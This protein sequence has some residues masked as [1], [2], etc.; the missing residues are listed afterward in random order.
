MPSKK[1]GRPR[2]E[3][4]GKRHRTLTE[5]PDTGAFLNGHP[6]INASRLYN[7][8]V[9]AIMKNDPL[10]V[11]YDE[12]KR[13]LS[14][15]EFEYRSKANRM[16][17]IE[18]IIE[19]NR[20]VQTDLRIEE[21]CGAW[22]LRSL[23]VDGIFHVRKV[24]IDTIMKSEMLVKIEPDLLHETD[25]KTGEFFI[26][27]STERLSYHLASRLVKAGYYYDRQER[28][29]AYR[30]PPSTVSPEEQTLFSR[31]GL[32]MKYDNFT[33]A[34]IAGQ[35][36]GSTPLAVLR[37]FSPE[38][39]KDDLKREIIARMLPDYDPRT[40][41]VEPDTGK[42]KEKIEKPWNTEALK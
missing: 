28:K 26:K 34:L 4:L 7:N 8:A 12:L 41:R 35:V 32:K 11:E 30:Q 40:V 1:A 10:E 23:I 16:K 20:K 19:R 5:D 14:D 36:N 29:Y 6:D 9:R 18:S 25:L 42:A 21:D 17:E 15:H 38:I 33:K 2:A 24:E 31:Y 13:W 39:A 27:P 3:P 22:Y 37:E